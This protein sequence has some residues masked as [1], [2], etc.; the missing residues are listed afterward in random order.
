MPQTFLRYCVVGAGGF[1]V[2]ALAL[3]VLFHRL[4]FGY[5]AAKAI[6]FTI[7]VLFTWL[8]NRKFTFG[9]SERTVVDEA[10]GYMGVQVFGATV[11]FAVYSL[12][13]ETM[14]FAAQYPV[15]AL[16]PASAAGLLVN[17]IGT[18]HWVYRGARKTPTE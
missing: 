17:F 1:A 15:S 8:L 9:R 11:N 18:S 5:Y 3:A 4:S 12:V 16:V 10:A 2:E 14:P 7:A 13:I 6:A